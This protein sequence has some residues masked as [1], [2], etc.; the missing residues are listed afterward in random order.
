MKSISAILLLFMATAFTPAY[1]SQADV[2][3]RILTIDY[4]ANSR[5]VLPTASG[6]SQTIMLAPG[7]RIQSAEISKPATF[8]FAISGAADGLT[9]LS[10]GP[11]EPATLYIRSDLR[12]YEFDIV[13][14]IGSSAPTLVRFTYAALHQQAANEP[15]KRTQYTYRQKGAA[16]LYPSLIS[17][18]GQKT[19]MQWAE[20]QP[21]PAVFA[22]GP[23]G[24]EEMVEGYMR[25]G[26]YTIDT[27]YS[28]FVFRINKKKATARRVS[29]QAEQK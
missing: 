18:D 22:I 28:E 2:D 16:A 13:P 10:T 21:M 8:S 5:I 20:F 15:E 11:A 14:A 1:A 3:A 25:G 4:A 7:E 6:S 27:I 19:Y 12:S 17:D 29:V 9:L 26:L 23:G 24:E